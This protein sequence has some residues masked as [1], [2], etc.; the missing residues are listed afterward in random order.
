M[1]IKKILVLNGPNLNLLGE[2]EPGVYGTDSLEEIN[3]EIQELAAALGMECEFYQSNLE[4]RL[5]E[6]VHQVRDYFDGCILNAGAYTHYSYALRDAI[7]AVRKPVIEVHM[8]NIYA[9]EEFRHKSVL[10]AVCAGQISGFGKDSYL[11]ALR[12]LLP[13]V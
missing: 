8:S 10:A 7:T 6:K 9:R 4:G 1:K 12:A 13:L 2:R 5:V 3:D 11:L